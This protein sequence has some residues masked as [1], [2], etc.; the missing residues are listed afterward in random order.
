MCQKPRLAVWQ[1]DDHHCCDVDVSGTQKEAPALLLNISGDEPVW[2]V[3]PL[4]KQPRNRVGKME[5]LL[6]VDLSTGLLHFLLMLSSFVG[7]MNLFLLPWQLQDYSAQG[8]IASG[9]TARQVER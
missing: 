3:Q 4:M 9:E 7:P 6:T 5:S 2:M 8:W 1:P